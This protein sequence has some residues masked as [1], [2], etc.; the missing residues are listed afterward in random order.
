MSLCEDIRCYAM[1]KMTTT[2]LKMAPTMGPL[3][4]LQQSKL[5]NGKNKSSKWIAH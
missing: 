1:Q 5:E 4:P 3:V 2:K